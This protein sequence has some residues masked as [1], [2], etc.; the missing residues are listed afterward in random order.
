MSR[1]A[2][3]SKLGAVLAAARADEGVPADVS[4]RPTVPIA[5]L[6]Q[7]SVRI[8]AP[9]RKRLRMLA[10]EH[11][12][13]IQALVVRGIAAVLESYGQVPPVEDLELLAGGGSP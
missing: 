10:V 7:L 12:T 13:T 1:E 4:A 5:D 2:K 8:T 9:T 6:P 11:D 3:R